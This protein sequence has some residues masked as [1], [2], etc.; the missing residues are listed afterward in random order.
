MIPR[1]LSD[2]ISNSS[3]VIVLQTDKQTQTDT[4][5]NNT[6]LA[7]R[8]LKNF[9]AHLKSHDWLVT[10]IV[11]SVKPIKELQKKANKLGNQ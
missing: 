2:D 11:Y 1:E 4:T 7:A 8:V 5:E 6:T 9:N 3:G 10:S